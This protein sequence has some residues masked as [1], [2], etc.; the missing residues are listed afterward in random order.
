MTKSEEGIKSI[1][2]SIYFHTYNASI[3]SLEPKM[4][5][6]EGAAVLPTNHRHGIR[7]GQLKRHFFGPSQGT[8]TDAV[9]KA[10]KEAEV[11]IIE[12]TKENIAMLK[13]LKKIKSD[14]KL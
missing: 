12:P 11:T 4:A 1:K 7:A 10:L 2:V 5:F 8:M 3:G 6:K 14:I 9:E 13:Q